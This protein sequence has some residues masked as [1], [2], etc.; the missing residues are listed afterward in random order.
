ME[1]R[2][3]SKSAEELANNK[4]TGSN[5]EKLNDLYELWYVFMQEIKN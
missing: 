4:P 3:K 5:V 2:F 1:M